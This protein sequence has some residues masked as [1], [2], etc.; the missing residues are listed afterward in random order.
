[1]RNAM[2]LRWIE[3]REARQ[4]LMMALFERAPD[5]Q[6]TAAAVQILPG[7]RW[8]AAR[9]PLGGAARQAHTGIQ[10]AGRFGVQKRC[11][12]DDDGYASSW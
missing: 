9:H 1:M 11:R 2:P 3:Q 5:P 12:S 7:L 10:P 4:V 6:W 8:L